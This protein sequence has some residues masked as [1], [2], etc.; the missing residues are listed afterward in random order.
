MDY[1]SRLIFLS[2]LIHMIPLFSEVATVI[3][4]DEL[5]VFT[6][7]VTMGNSVELKCDIKGASKIVWRR[8]GASLEEITTNDI[9]V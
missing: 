4:E 6:T 7:M 8:N 5:K 3:L 2:R 1:Q 9:K